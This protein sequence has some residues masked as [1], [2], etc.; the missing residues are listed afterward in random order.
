MYDKYNDNFFD[1]LI[2]NHVLEHIPR[3]FKAMKEMY[4]VLKPGGW[5]VINVPTNLQLAH[6]IEDPNIN[7]PKKQLELF[8]QPD[9]D[10]ILQFIR[11][12]RRPAHHAILL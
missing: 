6:T 4:R 2:C 12:H 3:D 1:A 11:L 10:D 7:D 9:H 8:G 5:A